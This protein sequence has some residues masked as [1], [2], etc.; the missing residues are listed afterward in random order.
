MD[1]AT[2]EQK[3]IINCDLPPGDILKVIAFAGTGKTTTLVEYAKARP[4]MTFLYA[5][6]NKSVQMEA[7]NKFPSNVTCRTSHA[8]AFRSHGV[9]HKDRL[10]PGFKSNIVMEVLDLISYADARFAISTLNNYL[11]SPDAKVTK[12]HI[13]HNARAFYSENKKRMPNLVEYANRLGRLMCDGSNEK[14][15]MLHDGYLKLYQLSKPVLK[16]D[17]ILLDEAQDTNPV[18]SD[19]ILS[20]CQSADQ[21]R[22]PA[23]I[24][25]V[26][27]SHQQIYSF[28]G[29]KDTLRNIDSSKTL[30]LTQ[31]FRFDNNI[32]RVANMVLGTFKNETKKITGTSVNKN[33]KPKWDP[34][35]HTIIARTNA[36]VFRKAMQLYN[37][38]NIGFIGGTKGYRFNIIGDVYNFYT[39]KLVNNNYISSF[40]SYNELKT[41]AQDVEDFEL[42]SVC[43]VVEEYKDSIPG[44]IKR[45]TEK[46]VDTKDADIILTTAHKAKGLEW[47]NVLTMGDFQDLVREEEFI[48]PEEIEPDEFNLI[49]VTMTRARANLRFDKESSL[50][51]FIQLFQSNRAA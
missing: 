43:K 33:T 8:L 17:C 1:D 4:H 50:P 5:A 34:K 32:A 16:F 27:D 46:A 44:H 30:F 45:I 41:Y 40:N 26:G 15:G 19:I 23:S 25:L 49:Y 38:N 47:N 21:R 31:S 51:E 9:K 11:V 48:D 6:F 3:K 35:N 18:T 42:L 10:V 22:N 36:T 7:Q 14:I 12:R 37:K 29:A 20:Q 39:G 28:R 24:I 2:K 13:P